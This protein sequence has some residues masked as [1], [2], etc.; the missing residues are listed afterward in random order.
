MPDFLA[1]ASAWLDSVNREQISQTVAI[2]VGSAVSDDIAATIGSSE[3]QEASDEG[4]VTTFQ[5]RDYLIAV[6][7]YAIDGIVITPEPGQK[8]NESGRTYEVVSPGGEPC[9]RFSDASQLMWRIHTK[10][11]SA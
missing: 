1:T 4:I 5:S 10:L 9:A 11:I 7:D 8:V 2:Q 3:F 6:A